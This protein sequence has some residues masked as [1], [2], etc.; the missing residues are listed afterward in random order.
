MN[1]SITVFLRTHAE[2]KNNT[3][4]KKKYRHPDEITC[5]VQCCVGRNA[6][7]D[8]GSSHILQKIEYTN[9]TYP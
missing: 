5:F 2:I 7:P 6:Y 1:L 4:P 3:N 8:F 9:Y